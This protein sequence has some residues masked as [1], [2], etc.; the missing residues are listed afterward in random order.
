[1]GIA[2]R[3]GYRLLGVKALLLIGLSAERSSDKEFALFRSLEEAAE[4]DLRPMMAECAIAIGSWRLAQEDYAAAQ[5]FIARG[6]S[7]VTRL[8]DGLTGLDRKNYLSQPKFKKSRFLLE[9]AI[10]RTLYLPVK[11]VPELLDKEGAFFLRLYRMVSAMSTAIDLDSA[12][13]ILLDALKETMNHSAVLVVSLTGSKITFTPSRAE[14]AEDMKKRIEAIVTSAGDKPYITGLGGN[15]RR[16]TAVWVP[17]ASL[18]SR[19][20]IYV[21]SRVGESLLDER[22][23]DFLTITATIAGATFDR[24]SSRPR[25]PDYSTVVPTHGIVGRSKQMGDVH[26]RIGIASTNAA[27]VLI[28]G[29]SGT[30]KELVAKAIHQQSDRAKGPFVPVDCGALPEGLI[31]AELF[32]AK[33]GAYTGA[34]TDR[35]GLFEAA[36]NG[37]IFLDEISNLGIAAQAKLLRVLQEREVRRIGSMIGKVV[38]VRLIAATN[39]NLERLV[40]DNAFRQDLLYRL[41]VLHI[42]LPPLRDRKED[43]PLLATT[44][45]ERLNLANQGRKYFGPKIMEKLSGHN[46]PGNIRELQNTVERAF[47]STSGAVITQVDFFQ[48]ASAIDSPGPSETEAWFRDLTEGREDFWSAVHDRYKRR[49][50]SRERVIALVDFGLRATRGNY[51]TMASMLQIPKEQYH[52]FMDFLRRSHCLLDF[53]PYRKDDEMTD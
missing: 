3:N 4:M 26:A 1:M 27:T 7:I 25:I 51:K 46:Y 37:T 12:T 16:S 40:R 18:V 2:Q 17:I 23:I 24:I 39:R 5:D 13:S 38:D 32:G 42:L 49:D 48:E 31:E 19:G 14:V 41:K 9:E 44:F 30:G 43:I 47:Y 52:R 20:G 10:Q 21:E 50:I 8:A 36:H 53:R 6:L 45:L 33:K 28:E 15:A 11:R 29:D 34:A 35:P 22:E